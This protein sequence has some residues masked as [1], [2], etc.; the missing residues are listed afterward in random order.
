MALGLT[1]LLDQ[2]IPNVYRAEVGSE[3][4]GYS[5]RGYIVHPFN[6]FTL[7]QIAY[8]PT[9]PMATFRGAQNVVLHVVDSP[10]IF[11]LLP[12]ESAPNTHV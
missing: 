6:K 5:R 3:E 10:D 2:I 8:E 9:T 12:S 7:V 1:L 4:S 11:R